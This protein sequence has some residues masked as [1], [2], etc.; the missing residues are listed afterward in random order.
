[1]TGPVI[2]KSYHVTDEAMEKIEKA[3]RYHP[4]K[5]DQAERYST[6]RSIARSYAIVIAKYCP[7]SREK[8]LALT[9][10]EEATMFANASI[11]RN[12]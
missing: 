12:E 4:P 9:K 11:A 3:F 2:P 5:D 6:I 7:D 8:S 1:M 10:L